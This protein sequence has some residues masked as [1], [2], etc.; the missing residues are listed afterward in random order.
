M[1]LQDL[2]GRE[3]VAQVVVDGLDEAI[4]VRF[5]RPTTKELGQIQDR[6]KSDGD[7]VRVV[8]DVAGSVLTGWDLEDGG[9]PYPVTKE[10]LLDL[11]FDFLNGVLGA[12]LEALGPSGERPEGG[13]A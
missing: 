10:A 2:T 7:D 4:N 12:V 3:S 5:R 9:K 1:R 6:L 11:P 13:R 8:A